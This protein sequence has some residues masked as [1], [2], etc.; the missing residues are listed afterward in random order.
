[1]NLVRIM[2]A[3]VGGLG[4]TS[5]L[6]RY[7]GSVRG[8]TGGEKLANELDAVGANIKTAFRT[9]PVFKDEIDAG[10]TSHTW[11]VEGGKVTQV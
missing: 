11:M 10:L 1:M 9:D 3:I 7:V 5:Q 8:W 6:L 4:I 2:E